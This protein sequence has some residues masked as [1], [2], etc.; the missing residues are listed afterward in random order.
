MPRLLRIVPAALVL[1]FSGFV[2]AQ[3][4]IPNYN[5]VVQQC[6]QSNILTSLTEF[7]SFGIK[8]RGTIAQAN[9]LNWLKNKYLSYGYTVSQMVED[10]FTYS[11]STC[12]N[13]VVTKIGTTYPNTFVII[14]G[15]YDTVNGPGTNDNGSG[16]AVILEI[17]RLLKNVPTEYSIKF[18]HFAGEE[19][20]LIGSEHYV[21]NVVNATTPKMDIRLLLNL[22]QVGGVA[23]ETNNTITC[24]R[25][26]SNSPSTN[27]A[28]SD[29]MTTQLANCME[30]YSVLETNISFAYASDYIPFEDNGEIITGL[31]E[32]NE[33]P[34]PHTANDVLANMDPTFVYNVAQGTIGAA[35][36]FAVACPTCNLATES[37]TVDA[38]LSVYPNPANN[39]LFINKGQLNDYS[40]K[41]VNVLG[42]TVASKNFSQPQP[43]EQLPVGS[44]EKGLYVLVVESHGKTITKKIVLQ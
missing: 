1:L 4:F 23:G 40:Y 11:G 16:T 17:A 21:N 14:D 7:Q 43:E 9:A 3:A 26:Q 35:L 22:D 18:I 25:D 38:G 24:E 36:H 30:L 39:V 27:N 31:Y 8:Y 10:P 19:D 33:S 28:A 34:F 32:T 12:K 42:Q 37:V 29:V 20:G 6:S 2:N 13:L 15:H 44:F 41:L 5:A